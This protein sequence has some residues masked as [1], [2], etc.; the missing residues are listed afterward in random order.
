M[1]DCYASSFTIAP[2][3]ILGRRL[4]PFSIGHSYLLE[5]AGNGYALDGD[6]GD[7]GSLAVAVLVCSSGFKDGL[8]ILQGFTPIE[9][10]WIES[11]AGLDLAEEARRFREYTT[12]A[13]TAPKRW[14]RDGGQPV[15]CPWQLAMLAS[16]LGD[17]VATPANVEA[18]FDMPLSWAFSINAARQAWQGDQS[19][20]TEDDEKGIEILK[21][22]ENVNG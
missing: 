10:D 12:A 19:L 15:K 9:N 3:V 6:G 22:L 16:M 7:V 11:C 14:Q 5:A 20:W 2:P 21:E 8:K 1:L 17:G 13:L 18:I 4:L